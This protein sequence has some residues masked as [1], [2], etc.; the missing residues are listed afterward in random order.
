MKK[1]FNLI[2]LLAI[3]TS[4]VFAGESIFGIS[5][6]SLGLL[7]V[8]YSGPGLA[9]SYEIAST[10]SSQINYMNYSMWPSSS[11]TSYSVKFTLNGSS[12]ED[13]LNNNFS[14]SVANFAGGFLTVPLIKKRLAFGIG[15]VPVSEMEQRFEEAVDT[16]GALNEMLVKGGLSKATMN[17]SFKVLPNFGI[18]LGYE[19]NFGKISKDFRYLEEEAGLAPLLL[20][21]EYRL[22]GHGMVL[23]AHFKP[24]EKVNFGFVYRPKVSIDLSVQAKTN[25]TEIDQEKVKSLT[26]PAQIS[27]GTEYLL[28]D[29]WAIGMDFNFQNWKSEYKLEDELLGAPFSEYKYFGAGIERKH[30]RKLFT[31]FTEKIDYRLGGFYRQLSQTSSGNPVNEYGISFGFSLPL[32]RFR[33]KIDFSGLMG[34]RGNLS[35]NAYEETFYRFGVSISAMETWFVKLKD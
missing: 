22:Y 32:Q 28:D 17:L 25:A 16:A 10:D 12:G 33:S 8:P 24:I 15:L 31:S 6:K 23:S 19:Y 4:S 35:D 13:R 29:R 27:M 20:R 2:L 34:K 7:S 1:I 9:R 14:N 11:I 5:N 21:Y 18:G 3:S 30:N 26:I